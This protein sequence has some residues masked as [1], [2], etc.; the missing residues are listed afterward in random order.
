MSIGLIAHRVAIRWSRAANMP[1]RSCRLKVG[2][3]AR[4]AAN[5]EAESI[6]E[7]V[8]YLEI[9]ITDVRDIHLAG[10]S[11]ISDSP[12]PGRSRALD[13]RR[14]APLARRRGWLRGLRPSDQ[15]AVAH[16]AVADSELEQAVEDQPPAAGS[17][18]VEAEAELVEVALQVRVIRLRT[19]IGTLRWTGGSTRPPEAED[20]PQV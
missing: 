15:V 16:R 17:A 11:E 14:M 4:I 13:A 7:L 12:G 8:S 10:L 6:S 19:T 5:G 2:C 1:I 3:P 9:Q 20:H 18:P